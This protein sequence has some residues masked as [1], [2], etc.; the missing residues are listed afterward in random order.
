M[1][2]PPVHTQLL[3]RLAGRLARTVPLSTPVRSWAVTIALHAGIATAVALLPEVVPANSMT[4]VEIEVLH[5]EKPPVAE[6]VL[7]PLEDLK[8]PEPPPPPDPPP[9]AKPR[10]AAPVAKDEPPP[11]PDAPPEPVF[12]GTLDDGKGASGDIV[13]PM[14]A[15]LTVDPKDT[16]DDL[17]KIKPPSGAGEAGG[18]GTGA[19][20]TAAPEPDKPVSYAMVSRPPKLKHEVRAT[21][22]PEAKELGI[23]GIV[24]L[25]VH[26]GAD[27]KVKNVTVVSGLGHGLDEAAV[28]AVKAFLFEPATKDD[29]P[30][31]TIIPRYEYEFILD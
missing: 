3:A 2:Q 8:E 15:S 30:V 27:G 20:V 31:A 5:K 18:T 14:G 19:P 28:N 1:A 24:V 22:P 17:S 7:P 23:E 16:T 21:Y 12:F 26:V 4:T 13:V 9:S 6:P 29:R 11:P 10:P 25:K